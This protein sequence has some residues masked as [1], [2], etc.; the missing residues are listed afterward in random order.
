MRVCVLRRAKSQANSCNAF[1]PI[2]GYGYTKFGV[3]N[4]NGCSHIKR[5][6]KWTHQ[7][8]LQIPH[9]SVSSEDS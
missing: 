7:L 6:V 3:G 1:K 2:L 5:C 4:G 9:H 8:A